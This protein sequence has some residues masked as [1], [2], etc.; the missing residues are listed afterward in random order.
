MNRQHVAFELGEFEGD[1]STTCANIW[2]C[3]RLWCY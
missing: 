2:R 1:V 3:Y